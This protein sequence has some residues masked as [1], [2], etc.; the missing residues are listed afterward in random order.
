MTKF[1]V[2]DL[3]DQLS[4]I[5]NNNPDIDFSCVE[6]SLAGGEYSCSRAELVKYNSDG[7]KTPCVD[8]N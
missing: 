6:L 8:I 2:L 7:Y 5:V 4:C 1:S 3:I